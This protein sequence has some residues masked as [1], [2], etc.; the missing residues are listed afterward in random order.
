M[1]VTCAFKIPKGQEN[2]QMEHLTLVPDKYTN[3]GQVL[4]YYWHCSDGLR[5]H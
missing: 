3:T 1:K 4:F 5:L 2:E